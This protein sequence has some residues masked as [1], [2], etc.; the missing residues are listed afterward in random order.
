MLLS[1]RWMR[2]YCDVNVSDKEFTEG[3]TRSGSKVETWEHEGKDIK[4]VVVGR[5]LEISRHPD[6][7]HLWVCKVDAGTGSPLQI[8][9]G[10]QNVKAGDTVP[11]ALDDSY[12]GGKH[13]V[14][15]ELRGV[16]SQGMLC[17]LPE[18]GLNAA[19][20]FPYATDDGIFILGD[21]C[22]KTVGADI[23][24]AIGLDDF[25]V[26][27]EI[28]PNR[29]DCLSVIGLAREASATF[30]V[31]L[32]VKKPEVK[33]SGGDV[34]DELSVRID[35][36]SL[37]YRYAGAVVKNVRIKPSPLWIRQRLR[38]SGVRPINNIVDI[39]NFVMLEYGQPMH[40]FDRRYLS[41]NS[42]IVRRAAAGESITTLDG[43]K[44]VLSDEMLVIAD[45]DKPVAVAGIMGGEYSGIMDDTDTIVFESA[46]FNGVSVRKTAKKL[47]MRT[48][49][50]SRYEKGLDPASCLDCLSRALELVVELG[51]GDVVDGVIDVYPAP[52][53]QTVIDFEPDWVNSFIGIDLSA[54]E[55]KKILESLFFEVKDGRIYVPSW[56]TDVEHKA[57]ISEEIARFYGYNNIPDRPLRGVAEGR[58]T[59]VQEYMRSLNAAMI[60]MG[61]TEVQ[62]YSFISPKA[63]DKIRLPADSPLRDSVTIINPLGED[64]SVMRTTALPTILDVASRNFNYRNA[65]ACLYEPATVYVNRGFEE[66]PDEKSVLVTAA[67][68]Q[69]VDFFTEKGTVERLLDLAGIKGC[70]VEAVSDDPTFHPG[71]TARFVL[72]GETIALVGQIHPL[73]AENYGI[74]VPVYCVQ[75][76]IDAVERLRVREKTYRP[77]PRFPASS[78]DLAFV[79]P[80]AIPVILIEKII[81]KAVG[82]ILESI[83]LFDVYRGAALGEGKK[84]VAFTMSLRSPDR[85][86]TDAEANDAMNRAIEACAAAGCELRK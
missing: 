10:A 67:Y 66:L 35:E 52:R 36:P 29:P 21:D 43:N 14:A 19:H 44:R 46:C 28:T 41:G 13:I 74:S 50:S 61:Y 72:D 60:A 5:V 1:T 38:A 81:A 83:E 85:T 27:F 23:H 12:V 11:V 68:G 7:D 57:D 39:T 45:A 71:R 69:D 18:L 30:G 9:T 80:A 70:D 3:M 62:T 73:V 25:L 4:N 64:S 75:V 53:S 17:S 59:P 63:Y 34:K 2:D 56:R 49:A 54:D 8:V 76:D 48:E 16:L 42:V 33:T 79:C 65:R 32:R 77:L 20:D 6:S 86:L 15:G 84:S 58:L 26:D 78:R 22:D 24:T 40:A 51:A 47:G 82:D 37:C 55:Q 31:P